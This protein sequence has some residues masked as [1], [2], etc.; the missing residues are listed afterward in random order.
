MEKHQRPH[1]KSPKRHC[2]ILFSCPKFPWRHFWYRILLN[3]QEYTLFGLPGS[4]TIR[5]RRPVVHHTSLLVLYWKG[6]RIRLS[7]SSFLTVSEFIWEFSV[8]SVLLI[9]SFQFSPNDAN[10]GI[11]TLVHGSLLYFWYQKKLRGCP[12]RVLF[13]FYCI[14]LRVTSTVYGDLILLRQFTTPDIHIAQAQP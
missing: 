3:I 1:S 12:N 9:Q 2:Y 6:L 13:Y 7:L 4:A 14:F 8:N 11:I 10:Q 5:F